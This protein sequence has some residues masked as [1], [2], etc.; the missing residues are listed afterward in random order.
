[1]LHVRRPSNSPPLPTHTIIY[2]SLS[3]FPISNIDS[4][5]TYG[6]L[7]VLTHVWLEGTNVHIPNSL[8]FYAFMVRFSDAGPASKECSFLVEG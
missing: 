3:A 2:V 8:P 7:T 1:M 6:V 4:Q 5:V